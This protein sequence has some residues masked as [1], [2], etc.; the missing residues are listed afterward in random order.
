[1]AFIRITRPR[2][3][4]PTFVQ[5]FAAK[6]VDNL[7]FLYNAVTSLFGTGEVIK[8]G[9]FENDADGDGVPDGWTLT[10]YP[11]GSFAITTTAADVAHGAQGIRFTRALG[12]GNGG[13]YIES[14]DFIEITNNRP[15][16]LRWQ[17]KSSVAGIKDKVEWFW[18]DRTKTAIGGTPSTTIYEST[19]NPTSW[20]LQTASATPPTTARYAKLRITG[21]FTD[22]DIAGSSYWDDV[23]V[24]STG[25][26]RSV[27]FDKP[28]TY[29]WRAPDGIAVYRVTCIG[30][31]GGGGTGG[32]V[33]GSGGGAGG[34]G[35]SLVAVVPGTDYTIVVGAG[36]AGGSTG[37]TGGNSSFDT[38][39]VVGN[40]G[41]GGVNNGGAPGV[42]GGGTGQ[43]VLSGGDGHVGGPSASNGEGGSGFGG[44]GS[45]WGSGSS[46]N[47]SAPGGGGGGGTGA[48]GTG[49]SGLV[50]LES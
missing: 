19:S 39:T 17:H 36:G 28:G 15:L 46:A 5:S 40:G 4:D 22:T 42:G 8:N 41:T 1:M 29:K 2:V 50:L 35:I 37:V 48:P 20:T 31:G 47:G 6:V 3:G 7:V 10:L 11:A 9:S 34:A 16:T 49:A 23:A 33:S 12:A 30:G 21:G 18:F 26:V 13:G 32:G 43:M 27:R 45:M 25:F 38:T 24:G 44:G 14:A